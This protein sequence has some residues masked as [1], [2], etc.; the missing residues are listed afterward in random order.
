MAAPA[1]NK[2]GRSMKM[3]RRSDPLTSLLLVF[4]LFVVYQIGVLSMPSTYNG[5]DLIT[6]QMLHL[7]HGNQGTYLAV[8]VVLALAFFVLVLIL[9]KKNS[10]DPRLFI[11]V[12]LESA[13]YA[14]TMG[15]LICFVMI[16]FLHIDPK[17][18]IGCSTSP[19]RA[20]TAAKLILSIGAGV[21]EELVFRLIMVGG[22][23]WLFERVF[24]LR[25]WL[26]IVLAF[27]ISSVLFSAAHHVIGGEP[28]HVGAFTYRILCGLVFA[29]IFQT[30][31][32]AVA[33][34]T[35]ALY[36]IYVLLVRG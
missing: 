36:D 10:F 34:Y 33:V 12:V 31:G 21:H 16:D 1:Y 8:N 15:S 28:F 27:A 18:F 5:A 29:T 11:P 3:L 30:R 25:R 19:E 20:G 14:L 4:P 13:I 24:G 35:H 2:K 6:S 23:V 26:A 7:L 32:F 17:L 9:R 22:G